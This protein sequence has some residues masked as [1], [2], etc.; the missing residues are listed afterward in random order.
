MIFV[1]LNS[2]SIMWGP[3]AVGMAS[4]RDIQVRFSR[5]GLM[6]IAPVQGLSLLRTTLKTGINELIVAPLIWEKIL[7][8]VAST[9]MFDSFQTSKPKAWNA[10]SANDVMVS[11]FI[12]CLW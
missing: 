10:G 9:S 4:S 5:A 3:W 1:G 12:F 11:N 7:T 6:A 2:M 8:V